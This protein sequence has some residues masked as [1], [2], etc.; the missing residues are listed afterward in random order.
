MFFAEFRDVM[1]RL[2]MFTEPIFLVGDLNIRLDCPSDPLAC[3]L[4]DDLASYGCANR[5]T[6]QRTTTAECLMWS[7][8][9]TTCRRYLSK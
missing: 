1:D 3:T 2:A 9:G 8:L 6:R 7:L 4:V 5:V